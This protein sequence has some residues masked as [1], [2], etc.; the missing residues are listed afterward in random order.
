MKLEYP[1]CL[2]PETGKF[3]GI[4]TYSTRGQAIKLYLPNFTIWFSFDEPIAF[5]ANCGP[6]WVSENKGFKSFPNG[7]KTTGLHLN[8]IN[9]V[10]RQRM[11]RKAFLFLLNYWLKKYI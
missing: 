8:L 5:R 7:T 1:I 9:P 6:L 10:K 2:T 11:P 4:T 3:V